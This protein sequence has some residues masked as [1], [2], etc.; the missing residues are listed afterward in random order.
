MK[1]WLISETRDFKIMLA[2]STQK[3]IQSGFFSKE[4]HR[5]NE[6]LYE[7]LNFVRCELPVWRS[8]KERNKLKDEP[9]LTSQLCRHL[10]SAARRSPG[11]DVIQFSTEVPDE[12][13]SSRKID[14][15]PNPC[16]STFIIE[17]RRITDFDMLLPI[18]CKRLPTPKDKDREESEY[19]FNRNNTTGG[20]QRF[21]KGYHGANHKIGAM[22]A[23]IQEN[24][25]TFW[26]SQIASW[27]NGLVTEG[28]D[29]W[30]ESDLLHLIE[31]DDE[32]QVSVLKSIHKR[33]NELEDIELRHL[34]IEMN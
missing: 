16:D 6:F 1:R 10:N 32:H 25:R 28:L 11:W 15:T 14:L 29:G 8:R 33:K 18:E 31:E 7:V 5:P 2:D 9:N 26:E 13:Y 17:G 24:S 27:I 12:I 21:K 19:V 30:N 22:I 34:W 23:Y 20:I 4:L 3:K